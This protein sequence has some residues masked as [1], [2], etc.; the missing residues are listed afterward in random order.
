MATKRARVKAP[1]LP[2]PQNDEACAEL[3][4]RIGEHQ[5]ERAR[6]ETAMNEQIEQIRIV[7]ETDARKHADCI[8]DLQVAVQ[9]YCESNRGRLTQRG[10]TY[11]FATGEVSWRI[12]PPSVSLRAVDAVIAM[13][14]RMKLERFVRTREEVDKEAILREPDAVKELPG[15]EIKQGEDFV[16]RP[17]ETALE[18]IS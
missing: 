6:I 15:I 18:S 5:R 13:F 1:A 8:K 4:G 10:K 11:R 17:N 9:A 16:V 12:R 3:I 7:H 2:V 14:K